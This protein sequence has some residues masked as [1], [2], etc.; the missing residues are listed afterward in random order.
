MHPK[1]GLLTTK[2]QDAKKLTGILKLV[3]K[4]TTSTLI[5]H[6]CNTIGLILII[7]IQDAV[8][9]HETLFGGLL[10]N[11]INVYNP[12]LSTFVVSYSHEDL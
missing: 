1:I 8:L 10:I 12:M 9:R 5:G 7:Y 11:I 3:L 2:L 6:S 4:I